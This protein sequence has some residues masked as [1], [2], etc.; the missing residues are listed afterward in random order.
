MTD[1]PWLPRIVWWKYLAIAALLL[2]VCLCIYQFRL[3]DAEV[4]ILAWVS[5]LMDYVIGPLCIVGVILF[6]TLTCVALTE[7]DRKF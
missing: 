3:F 4:P 2:S 5:V 1:R 6:V 7:E